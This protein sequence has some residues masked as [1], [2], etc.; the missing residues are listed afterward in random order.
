MEVINNK[1]KSDNYKFVGKS[2]DLK[3]KNML[4]GNALLMIVG[5]ETTDSI[6]YELTGTGGYGEY[7]AYD[8]STLVAGNQ[9]RGFKTVVTPVEWAKEI[10]LKYKQVINDKFGETRKVG[11]KL[12]QSGWATIQAQILRAFGNAFNSGV[13]GGDGK[14]FAATD[15]PVASKESL[16]RG[17]VTDTDAGT[18]SNL[19]TT[20]LT[21][22]AI[23]EAKAKAARYVT[24]DGQ[25]LLANFN[26]LLVSPELEATAAKLL[27][28]E[29]KFTPVQDPDND[30]FAA[31][32]NYGMKYLVIG[33]GADGFTAK[34]W[35]ICDIEL[36]KETGLKVVYTT[37]PTVM[38]TKLDNPLID[39]YVGYT[40][41][42]IGWGDARSIIFSNPA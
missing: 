31:N 21:G 42:A 36:F 3:A 8:G 41:F 35:A 10:Q 14:A 23:S 28:P 17:Y 39:S 4:T 30:H 29:N 13:L 15:H 34:Q 19:I 24:P 25:P 9:R 27:G 1:W 7:S 32:P 5:E 12:A 6:D 37:K 22:A 33:G 38:Q 16:N 40:D 11:A 18:Y 26:L 2:F 20:A